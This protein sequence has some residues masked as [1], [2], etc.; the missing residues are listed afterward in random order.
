MSATSEK[1]YAHA[2][3]GAQRGHHLLHQFRRVNLALVGGKRRYANPTL[4]IGLGRRDG[5]E[6]LGGS[7]AAGAV[8][9]F[10]AFFKRQAGAGEGLGVAVAAAGERQH[11]L[12]GAA[13]EGA[14]LAAGLVDARAGHAVQP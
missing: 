6:R 7:L 3:L 9:A 10:E 5:G 4:A 1:E 12:V 2:G 11:H 14:A 8:E 13:S